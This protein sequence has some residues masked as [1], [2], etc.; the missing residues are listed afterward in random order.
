ME[1]TPPLVGALTPTVSP[2]GVSGAFAMDSRPTKKWIPAWRARLSTRLTLLVLACLTSPLCCCGS[3]MFLS[4]ISPVPHT[5]FEVLNKTNETLYITPV[6]T[7]PGRTVVIEQP[8]TLRQRNIPLHPNSSVVMIN[9]GEVHE[10]SG[11]AVCR[12]NT[13]CRW[14]TASEWQHPSDPNEPYA[15]PVQVYTLYFFEGLPKLEASLLLAIQSHRQYN[16]DILLW[17]AGIL[18]PFVLF[19]CW[20]YLVARSR[21]SP[22]LPKD[23]PEG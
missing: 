15:L 19:I 9:Y 16:F 13:D 8:L 7:T 20:L 6:D 5:N 23:K 10:L 2:P 22:G 14:A 4:V 21:F 12:T 18:L 3:A 11:V 17:L 1:F